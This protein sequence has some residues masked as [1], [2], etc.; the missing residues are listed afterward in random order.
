MCI[1]AVSAWDL[2]MFSYTMATYMSTANTIKHT[3]KRLNIRAITWIGSNKNSAAMQ[4]L[5]MMGQTVI[6][7]MSVHLNF[8][9]NTIQQTGL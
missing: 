3:E 2:T 8:L 4:I 7:G 6:R 9:R 5:S 1:Q